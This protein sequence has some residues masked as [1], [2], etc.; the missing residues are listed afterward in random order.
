MTKKRYSDQTIGA[1]LRDVAL[2]Q[3]PLKAVLARYGVPERTYHRW[4]CRFL[5]PSDRMPE[6]LRSLEAE[7]RAL[8]RRNK[9]MAEEVRLLRDL[10]GKP[11]RRLRPG[12]QPSAT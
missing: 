12:E 9:R 5:L 4:R 3:E 8:R 7:N 11:W 10:L 6:R 1:V 2:G